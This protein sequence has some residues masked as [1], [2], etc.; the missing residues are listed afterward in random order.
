MNLNTM[1]AESF[2]RRKNKVKR[3]CGIAIAF[4]LL[5]S[6]T[7]LNTAFA[8]Y[9]LESIRIE[10]EKYEQSGSENV[11]LIS[12][13]L[14]K[15]IWVNEPDTF[16]YLEYFDSGT[17]LLKING[18][19]VTDSLISVFQDDVEVAAVTLNDNGAYENNYA[20]VTLNEGISYLTLAVKKGEVCIDYIEFTPFTE[21]AQFVK[22][23][24]SAKSSKEV[25]ELFIGNESSLGICTE[26]LEKGIF[27]PEVIYA[28]LIGRNFTTCEEIMKTLALSIS[29]EVDYPKVSLKQGAKKLTQL[30][31][32]DLKVTLKDISYATDKEISAKIF[33]D[34]S[35]EYEGTTE[36]NQNEANIYFDD[37][38]LSNGASYTFE[39]YING[40]AYGD[41]LTGVYKVIYVSQDGND[42]NSGSESAPF[43]TIERAKAEIE[44]NCQ[45]M[46]GDIV[47]NIESGFYQ[48][49]D[50]LNF[51]NSNTAKNGYKVIIR[52]TDKENPPIVS[53]GRKVENWTDDDGDGIYK[54]PLE[55]ADSV[56]KMYVNGYPAI[57]AMTETT[58]K[59]KSV[60]EDVDDTYSIDG[61]TVDGLAFP[62]RSFKH[63]EEVEFVWPLYWAESRTK[64]ES[65]IDNLSTVTFVM[66]QP[67]FAKLDEG[68]NKWG[69]QAKTPFYLENAMEFLDSKGE[70][71]YDK[72]E[73]YIYYYPFDEEN[74]ETAEVYIGE[75]EQLVKAKG[76]SPDAKIENLIFENLEFRYGA[77]NYVSEN[78][79][80]STQAEIYNKL[81]ES[82]SHHLPFQI[83][84]ENAKGIEIRNCRFAC[85]GSGAVSMTDGVS[86]SLIEQNTFRD[87]SGGGIMVGAVMHENADASRICRNIT[88]KNN[89]FRRTGDEYRS[90]V[91]ISVYYE[92]NIK[93][94]S[95]DI[96]DV[97]YSG[98]SAGWGWGNTGP[99]DWGRMKISHNKIDGVMLAL[100]DGA[101]IYTLGPLK[102]SS[103]DYNYLTNSDYILSGVYTDSGS[104]YIDIHNNV[105]DDDKGTYWWYQGH[106]LTHNLKAYNNYS[107]TGTLSRESGDET[108]VIESH[109][110]VDANSP[111][112]EE[113]QY[114]I[115]E[116][117]VEKKYSYLTEGLELPSW[118]ESIFSR[119]PEGL[120]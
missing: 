83:E 39:V 34:G 16:E 94:V 40:V 101:Q 7:N 109:N 50:T 70:F 91:P 58:Y 81:N 15:A 23:V 107:R 97:S 13:D 82:G 89:V 61:I 108:N 4:F 25:R 56:R 114:I 66:K 100:N 28:S 119:L 78:G 55:N 68:S 93:I 76:S 115:Y 65:V 49:S 14:R 51:D 29:E 117:G 9:D 75:V 46:T 85:L 37:V 20:I 73:G 3:I 96:K 106:T 10:A 60:Y 92:K 102:K 21:N 59:V 18:A 33:K 74:M 120:S 90:S 22:S 98:I 116:S 69:V 110:Y 95:N 63:L 48:I 2:M 111:W 86:D 79:V 52:G 26:L 113:A 104:A 118:R 17:Y 44:A 88:I 27:Y 105:I 6:C 43:K 31:D 53:G 38:E 77:M 19:T 30:C 35:L 5:L 103:I 12:N 62:Y 99:A 72:S 64:A 54:A 71:Y 41:V 67:T 112:P 24:N 87:L 47:V 32:G 84:I 57:R 36:I 42:E 1:N 8:N 80:V 45:N 11:Q